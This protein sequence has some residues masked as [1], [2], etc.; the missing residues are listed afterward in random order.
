MSL[1]LNEF[2]DDQVRGYLKL[3]KLGGAVPSWLPSRPL[4]VAYLAST[5]LLEDVLGQWAADLEPAVGW[6]LLLDKVTFREAEIEAGIDGPTVRR[7]LERLA[8]KAR[9]APDGL[10]SLGSDDIVAAFREI[11]GYPPDERGMLLLQRLPGLGIEQGESETRRFIDESFAETCRAGDVHAF[12]ENPYDASLFQGALECT[13]GS[14]G[15]SVAAVRFQNSAFPT[16]KLEAA[17]ARACAV[18]SNY[19]AADMVLA[20]IEAGHEIDSEVYVKDVLIPEIDLSAGMP[21]AASVHFQDCLFGQAPVSTQRLAT[22][23]FRGSTDA[24]SRCLTVESQP[25]ICLPVCSMTAYAKH[26]QWALALRTR[27]LICTFP[28]EYGCWSQYSKSSSS[29]EDA[30]ARRTRCIGASTIELES[31]FLMSS[32]FLGLA[33][34]PFL[35][36]VAPIPF[37]SRIVRRGRAQGELLLLRQRRMIH[38]SWPQPSCNEGATLRRWP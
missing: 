10:G 38:C 4:L 22:I 25:Q 26:L 3:R 30:A 18:G 14:L 12:A 31:L 21:C 34:L 16:A 17:I 9:S 32:S 11:C 13:A 23:L 1:S 7:I 15:C 37:G 27:F 2:T 33:I 5:G 6:N 24:S 8:T 20:T 35:V 28:W 29:G 36:D 19:L